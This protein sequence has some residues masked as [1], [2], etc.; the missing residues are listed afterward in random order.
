[1]KLFMPDLVN[2]KSYRDGLNNLLAGTGCEPGDNQIFFH[3]MMWEINKETGAT[4][5]LW[6]MPTGPHLETQTD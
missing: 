3:K 4:A 2:S 6:A 5:M 1:M